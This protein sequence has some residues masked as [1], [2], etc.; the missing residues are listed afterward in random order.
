MG[1]FELSK[2][3]KFRS[4]FLFFEM[5]AVFVRG[6]ALW[7]LSDHKLHSIFNTLN[8]NRKWNWTDC[9][10]LKNAIFSGFNFN[11]ISMGSDS[12]NVYTVGTELENIGLHQSLHPVS[13]CIDR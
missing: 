3:M 12:E 4:R 1:F 2:S 11:R 9:D 7:V 6:Y 10:A 5:T 8:L 13:R